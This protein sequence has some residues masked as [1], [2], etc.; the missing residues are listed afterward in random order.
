MRVQTL[1][2]MKGICKSFFGVEVLHTVDF[3]VAAG[4]VVALCGENGAG[5]EYTCQSTTGGQQ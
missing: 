1:V 5:R 4:E 3:D 2:E